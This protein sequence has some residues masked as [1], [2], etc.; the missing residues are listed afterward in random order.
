VEGMEYLIR[1]LI[2]KTAMHN[3]I[4]SKMHDLFES[5]YHNVRIDPRVYLNFNI[6]YAKVNL[7][8]SNTLFQA[9]KQ[10]FAFITKQ[11]MLSIRSIHQG[12][13]AQ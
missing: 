4:K 1:L 2:L 7:G 6:L 3:Y 10:A 13:Q 12:I 11:I 5:T 8:V 9:Q